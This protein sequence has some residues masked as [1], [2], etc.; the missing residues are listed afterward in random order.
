MPPKLPRTR[1]G[2]RNDQIVSQTSTSEY[3]CA[4]QLSL[5]WKARGAL[6][7][8][9]S[10][11]ICL[12]RR[13]VRIC[14][15]ASVVRDVEDGASKRTYR[16]DLPPNFPSVKDDRCFVQTDTCKPW[17]V[18][19][20][21][22]FFQASRSKLASVKED[23]SDLPPELQKVSLFAF[24]EDLVSMKETMCESALFSKREFS[25]QP[26]SVADGL[27][28]QTTIQTHPLNTSPMLHAGL[29][30]HTNRSPTQPLQSCYVCVNPAPS[31]AEGLTPATTTPTHRMASDEIITKSH[32]SDE[33]IYLPKFPVREIFAACINPA[34]TWVAGFTPATTTPTHRMASD[35]I[36]LN[37]MPQTNTFV[38]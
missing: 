33:H 21:G 37:C 11:Q 26:R 4:S 36:L 27:T 38:S 30:L 20:D 9:L 8:S 2:R 23:A 29:P 3:G 34:P 13:W 28:P 16:V 18:K 10:E 12:L 35:E 22:C 14:P 25:W 6:K 17:C 5:S 19:A 7:G 1:Y 15:Q 24:Q 32:S 31:W